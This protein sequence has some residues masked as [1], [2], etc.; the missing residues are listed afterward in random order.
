M[1]AATCSL[2]ALAPM[3]ACLIGTDFRDDPNPTFLLIVQV[4]GCGDGTVSG[5]LDCKIADSLCGGEFPEGTRIE[6]IAE[7]DPCLEGRAVQ[8]TEG[9][10]RFYGR[11][12]VTYMTEY[13]NVYVL[14]GEL[15]D[16]GVADTVDAGSAIDAGALDGS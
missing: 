14:F 11:T 7:D 10:E 13:K 15:I 6:L 1:V 2:F 4:N 9:G 12:H 8:W 16:A 5:T 3:T